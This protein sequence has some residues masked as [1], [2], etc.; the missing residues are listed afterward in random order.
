MSRKCQDMILLYDDSDE[1][2]WLFQKQFNNLTLETFEQEDESWRSL[3]NDH[4][5]RC[6][7]RALLCQGELIWSSLIRFFWWNSIHLGLFPNLEA[8]C[9]SKRSGFKRKWSKL[10]IG[11]AYYAQGWRQNGLLVQYWTVSILLWWLLLCEYFIYDT[12]S[13]VSVTFLSN[14]QAII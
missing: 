1:K 11:S 9:L 14:S 12:P 10:A 3:Y 2:W 5:Q 8:F 13:L 6:S 7:S 4:W